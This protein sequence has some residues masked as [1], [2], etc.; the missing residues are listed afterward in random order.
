MR[1]VAAAVLLFLF[2]LSSTVPGLASP[3]A[4][5]LDASP[6]AS[7]N[8]GI[9]DGLSLFDKFSQT[10]ILDGEP[11]DSAIGD[12]NNDSLDDIAV[13]YEGSKVLNIFYCG[14]VAKLQ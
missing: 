12:L 14:L 13:I 7:E 1:R 2:V 10:V 11:K 8:P 3:F 4:G 9:D 5:P 6:L